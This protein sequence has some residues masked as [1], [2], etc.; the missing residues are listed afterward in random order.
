MNTPQKGEKVTN[1]EIILAERLRLLDEGLIKQFEDEPE[2][3]H[4]FSEWKNRGFKVKRGEKAISKLSIWK[5]I[6]KK[7]EKEDEKKGRMFL[8]ESAFFA[9]SQVEPI[10]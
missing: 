7:S 3:I 8:K 2:Q 6:K 1:E 4:T 10:K 9:E 5:Y